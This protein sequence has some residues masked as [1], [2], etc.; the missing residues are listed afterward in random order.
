MVRVTRLVSP[1][2]VNNTSIREV[3]R[4]TIHEFVQFAANLGH[5][6]G[7][8]IDYGCGLQP[9]R[10]IVEAAGGAYHPFDRVSAPA[11]VSGVDV[12]DAHP[13]RE[14]NRWD[15]I[16]V[17]QVIQYVPR[18]LEWLIEIKFALKRGG[19]LVMTGPT[20]WAEVESADLQRY[21]L[22]GIVALLNRAGFGTVY[23]ER[24]AEIDLGGFRLS[25][26]WGIVATR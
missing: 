26:G 15:A 18:P 3:E 13:L 9:Y 21:T 24:R 23:G 17:N 1:H 22:D 11:N 8:V 5:F 4:E 2:L 10:D 25:L 12:G 20:N 7:D 16:L 19:R 6:D 14:Q